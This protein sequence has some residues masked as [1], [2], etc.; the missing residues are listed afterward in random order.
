MSLLQGA[1][2][3]DIFLHAAKD[4]FLHMYMYIH[5]RIY[6]CTYLLHHMFGISDLNQRYIIRKANDNWKRDYK[7]DLC[8]N[9]QT[10]WQRW[11]G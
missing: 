2:R 9:K 10:T 4:F 8:I 11:V 3:F 7:M 1:F 6:V 5:I